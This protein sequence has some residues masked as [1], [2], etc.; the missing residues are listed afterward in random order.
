MCTPGGEAW[1]P[2]YT[3]PGDAHGVLPN[4]SLV[5]WPYTRLSDDRLTLSDPVIRLARGRGRSERRA[6][7]ASPGR[8][9]WIAYR[10]GGV[11]LVKRVTW[12]EGATYPDLG[13]SLQCYSRRRLPGDR[14][15]RPAGQPAPGESIDHEETWSLHAVEPAAAADDVL[16]QLGLAG[17]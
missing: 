16:R 11:V 7:S 5:T 8:A 17:A 10:L 12:L 9:G 6:R 3:G 13:A 1:V 4:G 2:R 15:P 14:D